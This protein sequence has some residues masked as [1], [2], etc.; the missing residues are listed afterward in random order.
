[1]NRVD[2]SQHYVGVLHL[3]PFTELHKI[4][5]FLLLSMF[6]KLKFLECESVCSSAIE[7]S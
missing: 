7:S 2:G 4:T 3:V 6:Y 5:L 1:M